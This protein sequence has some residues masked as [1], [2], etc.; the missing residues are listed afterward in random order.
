MSPFYPSWKQCRETGWFCSQA[1]LGSPTSRSPA[2]VPGLMVAPR[3]FALHRGPNHRLR[4]LVWMSPIRLF[5]E[6]VRTTI[7]SRHVERVPWKGLLG[8]EAQAAA[9]SAVQGGTLWLFSAHSL[10]GCQLLSCLCS[11]Q[12]FTKGHHCCFCTCAWFM[13]FGRLLSVLNSQPGLGRA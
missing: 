8:V 7:C 3:P 4:C 10:Q 11:C 13:L 12:A 5:R 2:S 9:T 6:H 1:A